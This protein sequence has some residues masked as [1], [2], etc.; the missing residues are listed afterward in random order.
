M[1]KAGT[2]LERL[3][4]CSNLNL[5]GPDMAVLPITAIIAGLLAL[6]MFPLALQVSIRRAII[7]QRA[8]VIHAAVFGDAGNEGLRNAIRAFGNFIEYAPMAVLMIGLSEMAGMPDVTLWAVGG[9]FVAGRM[10]HAIAMTFRPLN[11]LPRGLAMLT[12]YVALLL[13]A[14]WLLSRW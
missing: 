7:G 1:L 14:W 12:T 10:L 6:I 3:A 13:P 5:K 9:A 4:T 8:G 2:E 11:P